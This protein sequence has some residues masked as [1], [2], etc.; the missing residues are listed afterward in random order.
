MREAAV[1]GRRASRA[2]Q[3]APDGLDRLIETERQLEAR[4][5]AAAAEAERIRT[6]A[7]AR[8]AGIAG[9]DGAAA[10]AAA[11]LLEQRI[12][13][14]RDATM[15]RIAQDSRRICARYEDLAPARI[16]RLAA[17]ILERLFPPSD[18]QP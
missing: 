5:A 4:L 2:A 6:D 11:A 9:A 1:D 17:V 10:D 12:A 18:A 16:D 7:R 13:Q 8:V 3:T 15:D 14:E